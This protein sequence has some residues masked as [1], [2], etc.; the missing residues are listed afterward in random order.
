MDTN[1]TNKNNKLIYLELSYLITGACFEVH[2]EQGRYAKERRYGDC[3]EQKLK[4]LKINYKLV[5]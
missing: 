5:Y 2:N 3:L 1:Y 4:I